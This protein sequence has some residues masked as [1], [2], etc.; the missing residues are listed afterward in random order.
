M[1][2]VVVAVSEAPAARGGTGRLPTGMAF[3]PRL[4][5]AR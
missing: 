4:V 1:F 3:A 5:V 2:T